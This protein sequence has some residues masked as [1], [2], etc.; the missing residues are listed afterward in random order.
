MPRVP[1]ECILMLGYAVSLGLI[2]LV[3][4]WVAHHAHR[5]T[6]GLSTAGFTYH[7]E[8][9]IWRCPEDQR[10]L[11]VSSDSSRKTVTY[12]APAAACNVCPSKAACTDSSQG[13]EIEHSNLSGL[14]YGMKRF[15]RAVSLTLLVLASVILAVELVR[16]GGLYP[17]IVLA[18][19]LT[20]FCLLIQ[21][22]SA[23]LSLSI[24]DS[25]SSRNASM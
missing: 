25:Q 21:H 14:E 4:E 2:A 15:H 3:L 13:R 19:T 5:R 20:L 24:Q 10:L 18:A 23:K 11:P 7:P 12:R 6:L 16:T 9:D 8:Q 17:R 1:L 22:L